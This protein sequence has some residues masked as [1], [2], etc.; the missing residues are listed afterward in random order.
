MKVKSEVGNRMCIT[1]SE[2][3]VQLL[4]SP[5]RLPFT[6]LTP[7]VSQVDNFISLLIFSPVWA[8]KSAP[9]HL[10][11]QAN[12]LGVYHSTWSASLQPVLQSS[13][14][15]ILKSGLPGPLQH[16]ARWSPC[17]HSPSNSSSKVLS[18]TYRHTSK[19]PWFGFQA[20]TI[21]QIS[22]CSES[23]E[24]FWFPSAYESYAYT[25]LWSI[26]CAIVK[27]GAAK[28]R[29]PR[30]DL[31]WGPGLGVSRKYEKNVCR[32]SSPPQA[33]ARGDGTHGTGPFRAVGVATA[34]QPTPGTVI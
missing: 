27:Q 11:P 24:F 18:A 6:Q 14:C 34:L 8:P 5:P 7:S 33:W 2:H 32:M 28:R 22:Q 15:H 16:A 1:C 30:R 25:I 17:L 31:W 4:Q 13:H 19:I 23:H 9:P 26:K 21:K 10:I 29:A 12:Q 20:T 3:Q